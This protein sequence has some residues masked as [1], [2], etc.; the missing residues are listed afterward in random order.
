MPQGV[1]YEGVF[2]GE[3]DKLAYGPQKL[4][5]YRLSGNAPAT[6]NQT[7]SVSAATETVEVSSTPATIDMK[8]SSTNYTIV[9]GPPPPPS[10]DTSGKSKPPSKCELL[11]QKTDKDVLKLW[12]CYWLGAKNPSAPDG[13]KDVERDKVRVRIE[14]K[15]ITEELNEKLRKLGFVADAKQDGRSLVGS[16][17]IAKLKEIAAI[18]EVKR[19]G[20]QP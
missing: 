13:C 3:R 11:E 19:I 5:M 17:P 16:L 14:V 15:Q 18:Q 1:S 6:V 2:G 12:E 20:K 9:P 4:A 7:V 8:S 10:A